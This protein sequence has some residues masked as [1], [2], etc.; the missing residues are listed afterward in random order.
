MNLNR[1]DMCENMPVRE[2]WCGLL[3]VGLDRR[4]GSPQALQHMSAP[5]GQVV[6]HGE[7]SLNTKLAQAGCG[8]LQPT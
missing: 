7:D 2:S 5:Q 4:L 1:S 3:T 8:L 6:Q